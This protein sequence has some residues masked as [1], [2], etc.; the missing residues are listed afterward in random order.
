LDIVGV[1]GE[2]EPRESIPHDV[3]GL[4]RDEQTD[5]DVSVVEPFDQPH[6]VVVAGAV[7]QVWSHLDDDVAPPRPWIPCDVGAGHEKSIP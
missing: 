1:E 6:E 5:V 3:R 4:G 2:L 7:A